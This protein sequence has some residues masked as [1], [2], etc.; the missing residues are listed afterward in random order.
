MKM[1]TIGPR[2]D[3]AAL[4]GRVMANLALKANDEPLKKVLASAGINLGGAESAPGKK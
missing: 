4:R 3:A 2:S 1:A